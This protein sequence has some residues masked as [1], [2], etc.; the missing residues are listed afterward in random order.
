MGSMVLQQKTEENMKLKEQMEAREAA[1]ARDISALEEMI[2]QLASDKPEPVKMAEDAPTP[3]PCSKLGSIGDSTISI[4]SS[5][6]TFVKEPEREES[7]N[8]DNTCARYPRARACTPREL[9]MM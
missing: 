7:P 4:Y 1:H 8:L 6:N 2:H 3:A 5:L 9:Q